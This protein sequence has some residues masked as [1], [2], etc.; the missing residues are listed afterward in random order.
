MLGSVTG[1]GAFVFGTSLPLLLNVGR[2]PV[3][4]AGE[5]GRILVFMVL[6]PP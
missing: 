6:L 5:L 4:G 3:V 1:E 2:G